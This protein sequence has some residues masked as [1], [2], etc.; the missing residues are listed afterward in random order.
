MGNLSNK[1]RKTIINKIVIELKKKK[2]I[3]SLTFVGSFIDK[4]DYDAI[5]D[6]DLIVVTKKLNRTIFNNYLKIISKVD[7]SKF[8]INRDKL[9]I[10]ASFGPLKFNNFVIHYFCIWLLLNG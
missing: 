10:N 7:P 8:G 5:N 3:K 1:L 6:I 4:K 9:K 2:E